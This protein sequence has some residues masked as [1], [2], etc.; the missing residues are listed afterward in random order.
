MFNPNAGYLRRQED[1]AVDNNSQTTISYFP[2]RETLIT[3]YLGSFKRANRIN[4]HNA[5]I[6]FIHTAG[7]DNVN[8]CQDYC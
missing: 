5:N 4:M 6:L 3:S 1:E 7:I 8:A 2:A